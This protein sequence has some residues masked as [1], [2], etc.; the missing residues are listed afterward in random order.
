MP[1]YVRPI[2]VMYGMSV[3]SD[4]LFFG[5]PSQ[6]FCVATTHLLF[7]PKAG[8]V[9]LAQLSCL[10]AELH[11]LASTP[12]W[13]LRPCLLCGDFN[14]I[15]GSPLLR[16]IAESRLDYS[17]LSALH[18]AGYF[19]G[20]ATSRR[21]PVPLL[22]PHLGINQDCMYRGPPGDS[23]QSS[24]STA[25]ASNTLDLQT[26]NTDDFHCT[27]DLADFPSLKEAYAKRA[28]AIEQKTG[29]IAGNSSVQLDSPGC[30][31]VSSSSANQ[32][33]AVADSLLKQS[34]PDC[35]RARL[36][37]RTS[38]GVISHPF[39]FVPAYPHSGHRP[40]TITTYHQSA[41]ETVDY[42]YFTPARS[43]RQSHQGVSKGFHLVSRRA[44]PS[45]HTLL[46][47]GPQPHQFLSS[48]HLALQANF[49][50][51]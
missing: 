25:T 9:K 31:A 28:E 18:I 41:I 38:P 40:S 3:Y 17:A 15:P 48:D 11:R 7:N 16:F 29:T 12:D 26:K 19:R 43:A 1:S 44:L 45:T 14:C 42:I 37:R 22:P 2:I 5:T 8:D 35:S 49:Q 10:L 6:T 46:E 39:T 50:L 21:I 36:Q 34:Q 24:T 20:S 51:L 23:L 47:L 30:S 33:T 13:G 27:V 4:Y 32:S